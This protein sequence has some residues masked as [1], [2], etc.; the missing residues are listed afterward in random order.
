MIFYNSFYFTTRIISA[1]EDIWFSSNI[2]KEK[3]YQF[4]SNLEKKLIKILSTNSTRRLILAAIYML[5][6]I[7]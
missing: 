3:I 7:S 2:Q 6:K 5:F 4:K 1:I